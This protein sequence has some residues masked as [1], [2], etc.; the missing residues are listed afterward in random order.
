MKI[1]DKQA[2][3]ST[4]RKTKR[5]YI[6][7]LICILVCTIGSAGAT[8]TYQTY[9]ADYH[10]EMS[11]AQTAIQHLRTG[12]TLLE[13]LPRNPLDAPTVQK[14]QHEFTSASSIFLQ[15][16][17]DLKSLPKISMSIPAYG[18][19]LSAAT[20]VLPLALEVSQVGTIACNTLGLLIS[21]LHDPLNSG[22]GGFTKADL[23]VA[24]QNFQQIKTILNLAI[25]QVNHLQPADLQLDPRLG[26][27]VA[28]FHK[29]LP[30][31]QTWL[32]V[33]E[34]LLPVVPTLLGIGTPA[35]YLIEVLDSTELRP[36]GG[37]I[38]NYGIAT[39]SEGRLTAAHITDV[40]L[41]DRPFEHA[42][43][44]IPYPSA[45]TWFDLAPGSWSFRDSNLDANFPTAAR[46]GE[47]TYVQEGGKVPVQG[48]I[49]ITPGLIE[50]ALAIIGPISMLPQ[51]KETVTAQN[52]I[53]RIHYHQLGAGVEGSQTVP[54]PDGHSS[55]RKRFVAYLAEHF[56]ARVRQLAAS[57]S[58]KFLQLMIRS[59]HSRD[60]QIYLNSGVAENLLQRYHL[61]AAIQ[62]LPGDSLFIVD[63]NISPNKASDFITYR[64]HDQVTVDGEGNALH[65]TTLSYAWLMNGQNYGSPIYRD[66]MRVYVPPG[67]VLH[68]QD[69]WEPRST[70]QA[71][72]REVWAGFFTLA[73]GQTK[74]L[75]FIWTV[76]GAAKKDAHGWHYLYLLQKQAG[77]QWKL[78]LQVTLPSCAVTS[79]KWGGLVSSNRQVVTLTQSLDEDTSVGVDY[80]C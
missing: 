78:N 67:S 71:F 47:Q 70:S 34:K 27:I 37:F 33:A 24:D 12:V 75:T 48:V 49:A 79:T 59:M 9:S 52:L 77:I 46:Y 3:K 55:L 53:D 36:G 14:A 35:N 60:L 22:Q 62:S 74:T 38:G 69:G 10:R 54:S 23:T 5:L 39:L 51:Y 26:K 31:L 61:D 11:L 19:R 17:R 29:D 18:A 32:G 1:D 20:H 42:G 72:G 76:P 65:H 28:T 45:Y 15:L 56:I 40:D 64:L 41:L 6:A 43:H 58:S 66:Y 25:D 2:V 7:I 73:F 16:D 8:V 30:L 57:D 4:K 21:R 44:T 68:R 50:H 80:N 13:G 63:A